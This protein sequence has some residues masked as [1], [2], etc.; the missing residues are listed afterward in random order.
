MLQQEK[1]GKRICKNIIEYVPY[2]KLFI[3]KTSNQEHD[4]E[5]FIA[6]YV[7]TSHMLNSEYHMTNLKDTETKVTVGDHRNLT[8][9]KRGDWHGWHKNTGKYILCR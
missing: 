9:K 7:D 4:R 2:Y 1:S 3:T 8:E 5:I 6:D